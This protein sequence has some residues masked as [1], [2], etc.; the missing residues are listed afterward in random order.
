MHALVTGGGGFLGKALVRQLIE[1]GDQVTVVGRG[2][3]PDVE[4]MGAR[5]LQID[6]ASPS[7]LSSALEGI[8][9]VF[10]VAAKA[11]VWGGRESYWPINVDGTRNMLEASRQAGVSRFVFTGSP[12]AI[13]AGEHLENASEADCPYPESYLAVYSE[14]K[15][16]AERMVLDANSAGFATTSLRPQ[17]IWGPGDPHIVPRM[18]ARRKR[19]RIVGS[20][21]N[22]VSL[23]YV[24]NAAFAHVLA[25]DELAGERKN[26]GKAY[27]INDVEPVEMWPWI[28]EMLQALGHSP[29]TSSV[30]AGLAYAAG[31][32]M[33]A[34]WL[35]FRLQ[36]EPF[37]TRFLASQLSHSHYYDLTAAIQDFGYREL[38]DPA[39]GWER[40]IAYFKEKG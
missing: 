20:G 22:K 10:H 7:G 37:M 38:V 1:R 5:C 27:F 35:L 14:T 31:A 25:A 34:I 8:G 40:M 33:E 26:A 23:T 28:N 15:A 29:I 6:L 32:C 16:V 3:Y 21:T 17:K 36:G 19:L 18:I 4:A 9:T 24:D 2:R 11:G 13:W 12:S 39:V 30:P